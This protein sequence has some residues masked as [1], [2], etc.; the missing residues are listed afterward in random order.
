MVERQIR[1]G[2]TLEIGGAVAKLE[3][4]ALL[5]RNGDELA[6]PSLDE[7]LDVLD[8][9]WAGFFPAAKA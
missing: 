5:R 6:M 4:L 3:R 1:V 8:R 9:A 7:A 2:A